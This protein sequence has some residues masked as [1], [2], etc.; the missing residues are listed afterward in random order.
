[1]ALPANSP[2]RTIKV[3]TNFQQAKKSWVHTVLGGSTKIS[4]LIAGPTQR[5][6]NTLANSEPGN[7]TPSAELPPPVDLFSS[8]VMWPFLKGTTNH[9]VVIDITA[10]TVAQKPLFLSDLQTFFNGNKHLWAGTNQIRC[11]YN[12]L[13]AEIVVSPLYYN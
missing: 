1:M 12:R 4:S 9:S 5:T 11:K 13:Y 2:N 3:P 6:L 10:L 7:L 8:Q